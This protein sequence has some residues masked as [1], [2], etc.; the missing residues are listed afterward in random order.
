MPPQL[1]IMK[2]KYLNIGKIVS[3]H[4][5]KGELKV[6]PLCDDFDF[7]SHFKSVYLGENH[8]NYIVDYSRQHKNIFLL[9]LVNVDTVEIAKSLINKQIYVK[10]EEAP[11]LEDGRF[12]ICELK[13]LKVTDCE[14]GEVFGKISDVMILPANDVWQ[15][16]KGDREFFLPATKE[17]I[18]SVDTDSG[19]VKIKPMKGIFEDED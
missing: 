10:R 1:F 18:K 9:K 8:T 5:I 14:T 11:K 3:T 6:Y 16:R 2:V 7:F 17:V 13:G 12:Y 4:G 15:I 19:V